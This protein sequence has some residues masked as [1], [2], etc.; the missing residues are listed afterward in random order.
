MKPRNV[1][2]DVT[3][4]TY[5]EVKI[6][7]SDKPDLSTANIVLTVKPY[8]AYDETLFVKQPDYNLSRLPEGIVFFTFQPDELTQYEPRTYYYEIS[9][10]LDG[11]AY[12][13][14]RGDFIIW[15]SHVQR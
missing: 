6:V 10:E 2:I 1:T 7:F 4:A 5:R 14:L 9:V 13:P 11:E 12:I 8:A 3:Q 15:G